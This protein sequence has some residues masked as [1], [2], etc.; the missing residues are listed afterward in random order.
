MYKIVINTHNCS[1]EEYREL[2]DYLEGQC[3]DYR[4]KGKNKC[5]NC[6]E[7]KNS[8]DEDILCDECAKDFGHSRYSQL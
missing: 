3:W 1:R 8:E 4:I 6:G 2:I 5:L 7:E